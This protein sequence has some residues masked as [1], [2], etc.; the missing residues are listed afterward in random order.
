M[1]FP[2]QHNHLKLFHCDSKLHENKM[3]FAVQ[4]YSR[5]GELFMLEQ[6][7]SKLIGGV[8]SYILIDNICLLLFVAIEC[9][10]YTCF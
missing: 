4:I 5:L 1:Y 9:D 3:S 10:Y 7:S 2:V 8:H 6:W